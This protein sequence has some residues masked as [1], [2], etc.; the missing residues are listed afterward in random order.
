[1][2]INMRVIGFMMKQMVKASSSLR[3]ELY[4]MENGNIIKLKVM[5]LIKIKT[6]INISVIG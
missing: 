6:D 5:E 1:M 3:M 4:M 2:V